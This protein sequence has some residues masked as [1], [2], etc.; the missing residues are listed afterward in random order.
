MKTS[1]TK[2]IDQ[3]LVKALGHPLRVQ[4]LAI[5]NERVASPNELSKETGEPLGNVSYH[6]RLLADLECV[7]LVKT[8]PRRGAVEH[9]YRATV[10]PWFEK[11]DWKKM[12]L[13][14]RTGVSSEILSLIVKDAAEA[15]ESGAFDSR[16]DRHISRAP[17]VLDDEAWEEL[18]EMLDGLLERS[19]ELQAEAAGRAA[20]T[21]GETELISCNLALMHHPTGVAEARQPELD[22]TAA[23]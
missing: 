2:W 19:L 3:R 18:A 8:E 22:K 11:A 7:E 20:A 9:Y 5:L 16:T 17:L 21:H 23:G 4:L 6:V 14:L 13:T 12:P 15:M 10:R 1:D